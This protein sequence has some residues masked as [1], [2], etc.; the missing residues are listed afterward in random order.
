MGEAVMVGI[1]A[2]ATETLAKTNRAYC[3]GQ[4]I[5]LIRR[6]RHAL[7]GDWHIRGGQLK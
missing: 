5:S 3:A 4:A 2:H 6:R 1:A 7:G